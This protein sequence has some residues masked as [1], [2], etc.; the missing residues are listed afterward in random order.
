VPGGFLTGRT[1]SSP[2]T[3]KRICLAEIWFFGRSSRRGSIFGRCIFGGGSCRLGENRKK[4]GRSVRGDSFGFRHAGL[5]WRFG[6]FK[7]RFTERYY[8]EAGAA[9]NF[10][11]RGLAKLDQAIRSEGRDPGDDSAA[12]AVG[13]GDSLVD[14]VGKARV[15]LP[16]AICFFR[17]PVFRQ[18]LRV[19]KVALE[20]IGD[21]CKLPIDRPF[22]PCDYSP[23]LSDLSRLGRPA[24]KKSL[25]T[26]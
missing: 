10:F 2:G 26:S 24:C 13:G 3:I 21:D 15:E 1:P 14:F 22:I 18:D 7:R 16:L 19:R 11:F 23:F 20:K 6:L 9:R 17:D 8:V 12:L 5:A 25:H 4:F